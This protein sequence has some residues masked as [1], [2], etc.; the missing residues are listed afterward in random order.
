MRFIETQFE[1]VHAD[2]AWR[3][4]DRPW[5]CPTNDR[6]TLAHDALEHF[7]DDQGTAEDELQALGAM[8]YV[9]GGDNAIVAITKDL[10]DLH[11]KY[12]HQQP[13]APMRSWLQSDVSDNIRASIDQA[14]DPDSN[15]YAT[16]RN[17][18]WSKKFVYAWIAHG[19]RRAAGRFRGLDQSSLFERTAE[20]LGKATVDAMTRYPHRYQKKITL[21]VDVLRRPYPLKDEFEIQT[22]TEAW[23]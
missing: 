2:M 14:F 11:W 4:R 9:R 8:Y 17:T 19:Y 23:S 12:G 21:T 5:F 15:K 6:S 16:L 7:P 13:L 22:R 10:I 3:R 18:A 20:L 1:Y